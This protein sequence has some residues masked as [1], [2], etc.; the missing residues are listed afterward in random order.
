MTID[1]V[2]Q[3]AT[4]L[5]CLPWLI[6]RSIANTGT[7]LWLCV[8]WTNVMFELYHNTVLH[9]FVEY[10]FFEVINMP[11]GSGDTLSLNLSTQY[12]NDFIEA[13]AFT[14]FLITFRNVSNW[15]I[16]PRNLDE[17]AWIYNKEE[18]CY[19]RLTTYN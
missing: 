15:R 1:Y 6:N 4:S 7:T 13:F 2:I 17:K 14:F 9:K 16:L 10:F 3:Q 12:F 18:T 5:H 11:F 8:Q 19:T